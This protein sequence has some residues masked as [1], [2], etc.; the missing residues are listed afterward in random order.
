MDNKRISSELQMD[1]LFPKDQEMG[2]TLCNLE[3]VIAANREMTAKPQRNDFYQWLGY[4][5]EMES[6]LWMEKII[7]MT[8]TLSSSCSQDR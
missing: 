2:F 7:I 3:D 6:L 1:S 5:L 8:P 4:H